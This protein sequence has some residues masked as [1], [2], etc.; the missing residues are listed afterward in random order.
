M[1]PEAPAGHVRAGRAVVAGGGVGGMAAAAA[2]ARAGWEVRVHERRVA[3]REVGAG[4]QMSPN[5]SRCL[6]ALGVLETVD[7]AGFRPGAAVLRDGRTGRPV[8][9]AALGSDAVARWGAPY[10][11][12]HRADLLAALTAAARSAGASIVEGVEV[13]GWTEDRGALAIS[14][15]PGVAA[16]GVPVPEPDAAE[17]EADLLVVADGLRSRLREP[18]AGA[19]QPKFAGHVAWRALVPADALPQG[20]VPPDAT[21]W[22]GPGRHAVTYYIRRGELVN[23]VAVEETDHWAAEGW[24]EEGDPDALR[25]LFA[26]WHPDL[27]RLLGAVGSAMRWGLFERAEPAAWTRGRAVLLGDACHPMLPFMAQ[28]AAMALEDAIALV[29]HLG[30]GEGIPQALSAYKAERRPRTAAVQAVSRAN[31]RLFHRADGLA[32][33]LEDTG[34]AAVSRVFPG[35]AAGRLD[36]LYGHDAVLGP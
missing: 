32:R 22:G 4:I 25:A 1:S 21:V 14:L 13:S 31:G 3:H 17:V 28:G 34:I 24:F 20:L 23:L 26:D 2:L 6:A 7:E 16:E 35:I 10:V 27:V 9:S 11:H 33:R 29:R 5:A 8:F 12:V 30:T 15:A 18:I 19:A 36:W